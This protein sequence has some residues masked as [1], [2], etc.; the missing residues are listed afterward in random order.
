[1][2]EFANYANDEQAQSLEDLLAY[3]SGHISFDEAIERGVLDE[4]GSYSTKITTWGVHDVH[5]LQNE[6]Y[7]CELVLRRLQSPSVEKQQVWVSNGKVCK[8]SDMTTKHLENAIKYAERKGMCGP[9]IEAL[10]KELK[11]RT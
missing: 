8:P 1:M 7:K 5:S 6:I 9:A 2:G 10:K 3:E 4:D 11:K